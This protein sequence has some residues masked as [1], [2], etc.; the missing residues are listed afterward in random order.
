MDDLCHQTQ[1]AARPLEF[2][3]RPPTRVELVKELWMNGVCLFQLAAIIF[4]SAALRKI[5]RIL[6][7]ELRELLQRIV[8]VM[9]LVARNFL[10]QAP[11]DDLVAF[12]LRGRSPRR[13][14][15]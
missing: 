5:I 4:V 8:L 6:A 3:K 15:A 12:F 13:F 2:F 10:E 1:H 7:I 11:A 9:V 14:D